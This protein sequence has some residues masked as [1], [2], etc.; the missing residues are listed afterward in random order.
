MSIVAV[1]AL[2]LV[3]L[4]QLGLGAWLM[5]AAIVVALA[6]R[7]ALPLDMPVPELPP[8]LLALIGA[9][10]LLLFIAGANVFAAVVMP[11]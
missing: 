1:I 10:G 6:P 4:I 11:V 2:T 7:F 5:L 9:V 8:I 3:A